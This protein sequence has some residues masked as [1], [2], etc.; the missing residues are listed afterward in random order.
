[1]PVT[2][3]QIYFVLKESFN[4]SLAILSLV[5]STLYKNLGL[6][7][8]TIVCETRIR[9][10]ENARDTSGAIITQNT[11]ATPECN[12]HGTARTRD[13]SR[14][15]IIISIIVIADVSAVTSHPLRR[16]FPAA[17]APRAS[18]ETPFPSRVVAIQFWVPG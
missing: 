7:D 11:G 1:M 6:F 17:C 8:Q 4:Y 3:F 12:V 5:H 14:D 15:V 18:K 13:T 9:A 10:P 2:I 16:K